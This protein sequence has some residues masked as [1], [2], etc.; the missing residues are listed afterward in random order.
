[1]LLCNMKLKIEEEADSPSFL[2]LFW[3]LAMIDVKIRERAT[4]QLLSYLKEHAEDA[5]QPEFPGL[6]R[7]MIYTLKRLCNG[8]SSSRDCAR[9]GFSVALTYPFIIE[10]IVNL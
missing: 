3:D 6:S 7:E 5:N 4:K 2:N 1:M 10:F 9:Q 8:V